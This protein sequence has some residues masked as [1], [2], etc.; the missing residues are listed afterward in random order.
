MEVK[1]SFST[2]NEYNAVFTVGSNLGRK[3]ITSELPPHVVTKPCRLYIDGREKH[4]GGGTLRV[5]VR[6]KSRSYDCEHLAQGSARCELLTQQRETW[7]HSGAGLDAAI[8]LYIPGAAGER[9]V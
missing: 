1:H 5:L 8:N 3:R 9:L 2:G 7:R 4:L 6:N